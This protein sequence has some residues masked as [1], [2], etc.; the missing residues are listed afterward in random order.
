M[1]H[2]IVLSGLLMPHLDPFRRELRQ[3]IQSANRHVPAGPQRILVDKCTIMASTWEPLD[4][5]VLLWTGMVSKAQ[6]AP[7]PYIQKLPQRISKALLLLGTFRSFVRATRTLCF[8]FHQQVTDLT[9]DIDLDAAP[10]SADTE[11][12]WEEFSPL[13]IT[14]EALQGMSLAKSSPS[15]RRW[16]RLN[17]T[18]DLYAPGH[19]LNRLLLLYWACYCS[20]LEVFSSV[21]VAFARFVGNLTLIYS[22]KK[23]EKN[24][25]RNSSGE[26]GTEASV[27]VEGKST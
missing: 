5:R 1:P 21:L 6:R 18:I 4:D 12:H 19:F 26:P 24:A 3:S 9:L 23:W 20:T 13:S 27:C 22:G 25:L 16:L 14:P 8:F 17:S 7:H 2:S 10:T 11:D 15:G